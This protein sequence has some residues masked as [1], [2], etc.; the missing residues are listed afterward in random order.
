MRAGTSPRLA[1]AG[2]TL[3]EIMVAL[4]VFGL[5]ALALIRLEGQTI[6]STTAVRDTLSAQLVARNVAID[7]VTAATS[8]AVGT[9]QGVEANGGRPWRWTRTVQPLGDAGATRI[10]VAVA[11]ARGV[12][13]G[14]MTM[15]RAAR[16]EEMAR[17]S[18]SAPGATTPPPGTGAPR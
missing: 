7:A 5:A 6:R 12:A 1:E 14:R 16:D 11:D 4:V 17:P 9:A 10:D 8:P 13:L 15:V 2:F 3:I 18:S